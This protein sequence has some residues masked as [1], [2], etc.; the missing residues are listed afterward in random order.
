MFDRP[1]TWGRPGNRARHG[2][3]VFSRAE[4]PGTFT[5]PAGEV[6]LRAR[7]GHSRIRPSHRHRHARNRAHRFRLSSLSLSSSIRKLLRR[8]RS[9][10]CHV[11]CTSAAEMSPPRRSLVEHIRSYL[12][13]LPHET[14]TVTIP[15]RIEFSTRHASARLFGLLF[16]F[17][18]LFSALASFPLFFTSLVRPLFS[19][20]SYFTALSGSLS[21]FT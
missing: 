15:A 7:R 4:R 8:M 12:Y 20:S 14:Q 9:E 10:F 3:A 13:T 1:P 5:L 6:R 18:F 2:N 21:P 16:L 17:L 19:R 11:W